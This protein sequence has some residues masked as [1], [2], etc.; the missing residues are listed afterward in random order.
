MKDHH[1][2][3]SG[4]PQEAPPLIDQA[5]ARALG[6][7]IAGPGGEELPPPPEEPLALMPFGRFAGVPVDAV[8]LVDP[9][10]LR[11]AL[12]TRLLRETG[13]AYKVAR[14][15]VL[16]GLLAELKAE[17][18]PHQLQAAEAALLE[19]WRRAAPTSRPAR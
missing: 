11:W 7:R 6:Y 12:C 19:L 1:R 16:Q 18:E 15:R 9:F 2:Y 3:R 4:A 13:E 17:L 14:D 10:Y 5:G 8:A